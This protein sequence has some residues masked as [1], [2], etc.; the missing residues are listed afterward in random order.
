MG[1]LRGLPARIGVLPSRFV[2]QTDSEG[3]SVALEPW[4]RWYKTAE[5]SAL[6][7]RVFLRDLYTC[8]MPGC[9]AITERP[10]ADHRTPHRGDR[11]LFFDASN[12]QTLCKPCHDG[13]KQRQERRWMG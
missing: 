3:H 8:Q 13:P 10:V 5:W 2:R 9:T 6:R 12:V 1:S 11:D 7:S 4:R